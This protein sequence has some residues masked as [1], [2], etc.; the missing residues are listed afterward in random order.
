MMSVELTDERK[1]LIWNHFIEQWVVGGSGGGTGVTGPRLRRI[2][3]YIWRDK[4]FWFD[5]AL[6]HGLNQ[7]T[8]EEL[9][10]ESPSVY[11]H[12]QGNFW[13]MIVEMLYRRTI[14]G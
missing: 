6:R 14:N 11:E 1:H 8:P 3:P 13:G 10:L 7:I 5:V 12:A 2:K 4:A 9:K